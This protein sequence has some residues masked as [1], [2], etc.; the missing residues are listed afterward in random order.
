MV[1]PNEINNALVFVTILV[2]FRK[3]V[4]VTFKTCETQ[5]AIASNNYGCISHVV[6]FEHGE[7][8]IEITMQIPNNIEIW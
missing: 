1:S 2:Q 3:S 4:F 8:I 7:Q 5:T 6:A